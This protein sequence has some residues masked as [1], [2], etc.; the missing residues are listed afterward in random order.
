MYAA[1]ACTWI[2]D[3]LPLA[4]RRCLSAFRVVLVNGLVRGVHTICTFH[5]DFLAGF[6]LA[7]ADLVTG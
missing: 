7:H 2:V 3:T 5:P 4:F 1:G 6:Q